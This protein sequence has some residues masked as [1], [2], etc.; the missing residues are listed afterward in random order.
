MHL[1]KVTIAKIK[2][3]LQGK[4]LRQ[5]DL[6][7]RVNMTPASVSRI[8]AGKVKTMDDQTVAVFEDV[9]GIRLA[10]V[11]LDSGS[12]NP[13]ALALSHLAEDDPRIAQLLDLMV[14]VIRPVALSD[15]ELVKAAKAAKAVVARHQTKL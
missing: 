7:K 4:G 9:L 10:P 3:A 14:S 6:A 5:S 13:S 1:E 8:L 12:V 15:D 2:F 11:P